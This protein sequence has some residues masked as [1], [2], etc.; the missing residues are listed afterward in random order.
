LRRPS[1][2]QQATMPRVVTSPHRGHMWAWPAGRM[3]GR[4]KHQN[5]SES[6]DCRIAA[7]RGSSRCRNVAV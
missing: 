3:R 7:A 6:R 2:R 5:D 4:K 1:R